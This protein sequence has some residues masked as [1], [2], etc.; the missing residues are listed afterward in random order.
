MNRDRGRPQARPLSAPHWKYGSKSLLLLVA[1]Q[2]SSDH[3]R[4]QRV[5]VVF[6]VVPEKLSQRGLKMPVLKSA[7]I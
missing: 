7:R 6:E 4:R 5:S 1:R 2:H 3:Q